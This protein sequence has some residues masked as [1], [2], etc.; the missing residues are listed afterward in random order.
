MFFVHTIVIWTMYYLMMYLCFFAYAHTSGLSP[1]AALLA[2]TFG[3]FGMVIPSPG[4][5]GTYQYAVTAALVIYGVG[6]A[7]AFAF[8]NIIF[9]TISLFCNII[10]GVLAYIL[11]PIYNKGYEPVLPEDNL[12]A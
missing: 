6:N 11:V 5:M 12:S 4:G 1:M 8:S 3:T 10:F 2:F 7:D 9:F